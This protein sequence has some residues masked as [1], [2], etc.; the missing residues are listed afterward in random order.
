VNKQSRTRLLTARALIVAL[1][2][3]AAPMP[4]L[5]GDNNPTTQPTPV[6]KNAIAKAV[7]SAPLAKAPAQGTAVKS[8]KS[9]LGSVGFFKKPAG[10][11]ALVVVLVGGGYMGYSLSKD[12]IHS[13]IRATQ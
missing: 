5:A 3:A 10:I 11:I 7:A 1:V 13:V 2:I 12:R 8:D 6:L 9:E 4:S